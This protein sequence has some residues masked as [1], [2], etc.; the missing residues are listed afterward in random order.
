MSTGLKVFPHMALWMGSTVESTEIFVPKST[1]ATL[2]TRESDVGSDM[3][4]FS[5]AF[6]V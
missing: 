5:T 1:P 4:A 2:L 6:V 3:A